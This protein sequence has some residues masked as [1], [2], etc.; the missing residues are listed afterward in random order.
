MSLRVYLYELDQGQSVRKTA[1][2][3]DSQMARQ[4]DDQTDG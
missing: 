4:T 2:Q 3:P 1:R